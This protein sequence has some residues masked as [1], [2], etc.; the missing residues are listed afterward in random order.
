MQYWMNA[1]RIAARYDWVDPDRTRTP[2]EYPYNFDAH[3][4]W[5]EDLEGADVVYSD[6]MWQSDWDLAKWAFN[7]LGQRGNY[8]R[9]QCKDIVDAY[10]QGRYECVGYALACNQS[11]GYE[12]GMFYIK[13]K[14]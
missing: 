7:G 14:T 5:R 4:K 3:F 9:Q 11:S 2:E 8:T 12:I 10:Y 1:N 6:R 13:A